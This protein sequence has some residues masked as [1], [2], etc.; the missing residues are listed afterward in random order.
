MTVSPVVRSLGRQW[1]PIEW[2]MQMPG[3]DLRVGCEVSGS[4]EPIN[5]SPSAPHLRACVVAHQPG[6]ASASDIAR[7]PPSVAR[8]RRDKIRSGSGQGGHP[9]ITTEG[10]AI[11]DAAWCWGVPGARAVNDRLSWRWLFIE[12]GL[13]R[14]QKH[15]QKQLSIPDTSPRNG[16]RSVRRALQTRR[17][18]WPTSRLPLGRWCLRNRKS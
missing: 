1:L 11:S 13:R 12:T 5:R 18:P 16:R 15:N 7:T 17:N 9:A 8:L 4:T 3:A 6:R 14:H 2:V 10:R